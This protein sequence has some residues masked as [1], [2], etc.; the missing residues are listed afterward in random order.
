MYDFIYNFLLNYSVC[1][2]FLCN[3]NIL[4]VKLSN[5]VILN[6]PKIALGTQIMFLVKDSFVY[7]L[8]FC[9][10]VEQIY[11]QVNV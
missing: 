10:S 9:K 1:V 7:F 4:H 8:P 3:L 5:M 6:F 2:Q 11:G